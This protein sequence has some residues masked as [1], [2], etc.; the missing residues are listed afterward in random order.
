MT[1]SASIKLFIINNRKNIFYFFLFLLWLFLLWFFLHKKNINKNNH[2]TKVTFNNKNTIKEINLNKNYKNKEETKLVESGKIETI[3]INMTWIISHNI[4]LQNKNKHIPKRL[5]LWVDQKSMELKD[6]KLTKL[7]KNLEI[8][9]GNLI[10]NDFF[11]K[12]NYYNKTNANKWIAIKY[13]RFKIIQNKKEIIKAIV[14]YVSNNK[15]W[16]YT[17]NKYLNENKINL[18]TFIENINWLLFN[19]IKKKLF[20]ITIEDWLINNLV[21]KKYKWWFWLYGDKKLND[22]LKTTLSSIKSTLKVTNE[23]DKKVFQ[24]QSYIEGLLL[25]KYSGLLDNPANGEKRHNNLLYSLVIINYYVDQ[26]SNSLP[27]NIIERDIIIDMKNKIN[28]MKISNWD[29][30]EILS[31]YK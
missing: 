2:N 22:I 15:D 11:D 1:K 26:Y 7:K 4:P 17:I 21:A 16:Q 5:I 6:D 18:I 27:I 14:S 30:K 9:Q 28:K 31:I 29:K 3:Q 23:Q 25:N 20:S 12:I 13:N 19:K 8:N 10:Y 24:Q